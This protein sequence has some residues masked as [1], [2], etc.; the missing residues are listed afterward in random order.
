MKNL[1]APFIPFI[2]FSLFVHRKV[3]E[4]N[5]TETVIEN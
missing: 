4:T 5:K 1:F 3:G 2:F